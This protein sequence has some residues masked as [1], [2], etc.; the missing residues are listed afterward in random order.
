MTYDNPTPELPTSAPELPSAASE[1]PSNAPEALPPTRRQRLRLQMEAALLNR[2]LLTVTLLLLLTGLVARTLLFARETPSRRAL[3][4]LYMDSYDALSATKSAYTPGLIFNDPSAQ[5]GS[6]SSSL[7]ALRNASGEK[8]HNAASGSGDGSNT[9]MSG[10]HAATGSAR[11]PAQIVRSATAPDATSGRSTSARFTKKTLAQARGEQAAQKWRDAAQSKQAQAAEW[12][13]LGIVLALFHRPGVLEALAHVAD[14]FPPL[15]VS[16]SS[17]GRASMQ[18]GNSNIDPFGH[19]RTGVSVAQEVA[20]WQAVYGAQKVTAAQAVGLRNTLQQLRL[21]WFEN[22][23][24]AHLYQKAGLH[25]DAVR[26]A[27]EANRTASSVRAY[28]NT[29]INIML[30]GFVGL[31][32]GGVFA[33]VRFLQSH[34]N[35]RDAK[36]A[37]AFFIQMQAIPPPPAPFNV[38]SVYAPPSQP[39]AE[40]I[41]APMY[42]AYPAGQFQVPAQTGGGQPLPNFVAPSA[43]LLPQQHSATSRMASGQRNAAQADAGDTS[44]LKFLSQ[45]LPASRADVAAALLLAFI[46][47]LVGHTGL[48]LLTRYALR[49]FSARLDAMTTSQLM[50]LEWTL[51]FAL[52]IPVMLLP[53]LALRARLARYRQ[54]GEALKLRELLAHLGYRTRSLPAEIKT[55]VFGYILLAPFLLLAGLVSHALFHNFHTPV[56]PAQFETMAAQQMVDKVL[57]FALAAVVAPIVEET[58]FRGLL[59]SALRARFGIGG[60]AMLS[61]AAFSL[62]HPTLP[63]GFLTIWAIGIAL[64]LVYERR[65]SLVPG[66]ILHGIHNGLITLLGFAVFGK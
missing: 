56:N 8:N 20:A 1:M 39:Q 37:Q 15:P 10:A 25:A 61:A 17:P 27:E 11:P 23:A 28:E 5:P 45:W 3:S 42:P 12:R 31:F 43:P 36:A 51:Q 54:A 38:P 63:G 55:A 46:L 21:G 19:G 18:T 33:L 57:I 65:G 44:R 34:R 41:A 16:E 35:R 49:P 52:Y 30:F 7:L 62:V 4:S 50:R 14:K 22:I 13:R 29:E 64:A 58:M 48:G 59:Y 40:G 6:A 47:Y 32:F 53:L 2:R 60:A 66:I 24:L 26:A 9:S